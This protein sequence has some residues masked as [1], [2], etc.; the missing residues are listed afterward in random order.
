MFFGHMLLAINKED[1]LQKRI[2]RK[3]QGVSLASVISSNLYVVHGT[4]L[5]IYNKF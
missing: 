5:F 1:K 4:L 2:G 3:G